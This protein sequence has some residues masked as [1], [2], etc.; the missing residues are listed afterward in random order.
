MP[1]FFLRWVV[2]TVLSL[3]FVSSPQAVLALDMN[4]VS[5]QFKHSRGD[6]A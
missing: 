2:I 3:R 1:D 5:L 4:G 6:R